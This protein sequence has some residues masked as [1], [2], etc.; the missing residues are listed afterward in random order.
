MRGEYCLYG[1][2][3]LSAMAIILLVFAHIGQ[4]SSGAVTSGIYMAQINVAAYG[5]AYQGGT[6]DSAGGL[7][8]TKNDALGTG[9]G[10]RQYYR[11]G[12][13]NACGYQKD[14]SG[15]CNGTIFGYPMEPLSQILAD[16]PTKFKTQTN[17]II[18]SSTFKDNG[19]NHG[20]SRGG[21]LLIFVGSVFAVISIIFGVLKARICFLIAAASAGFSAL[22]L[23]IGAAMWTSL[24]A[25]DAWL[26]IVK[27]KGGT[28]LGIYTTGG[29]SLYLTWVAFV[30]MTLS[31]IPY[32]VACCTFRR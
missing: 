13:Y 16:T 5:N 17:D 32:V 11:Y 31:V 7:Y 19:F 23:M 22:L 1:A 26:K 29:A 12:L 6:G 21:S 20:L 27:V 3:A 28:L 15:I 30:L 24:I 9:K 10:L 14:G 25:K 2:T 8:D 18:P 4:V